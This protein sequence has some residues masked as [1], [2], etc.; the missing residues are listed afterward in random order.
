MT[1]KKHLQQ[2]SAKIETRNGLLRRLAGASW[3]ANFDVLRMSSLAL[4]YSAAEYCSPVWM[5]SKHTKLIDTALNNSMSTITG[6]IR[7]TPTE[8]LPVLSGHRSTKHLPT[9]NPP[10]HGKKSTGKLRPISCTTL[11]KTQLKDA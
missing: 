4:S 8:Q 3:G 7:P 2:I 11:P 9:S 1:F 10:Q 6:C 5:T